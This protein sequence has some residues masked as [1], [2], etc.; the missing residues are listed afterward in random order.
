VPPILAIREEEYVVE[1]HI[2]CV[3]HGYPV[4]LRTVTDRLADRKDDITPTL[5]RKLIWKDTRKL[6]SRREV[7]AASVC[8]RL[9]DQAHLRVEKDPEMACL[10]C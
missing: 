8:P 9:E 2:R 10:G 5:V 6:G 3:R 1:R 7:L 4:E